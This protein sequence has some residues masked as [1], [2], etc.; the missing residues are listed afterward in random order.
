LD[1]DT[2]KALASLARTTGMTISEI[3]KRGVSALE[4]AVTE[5]D[6]RKPY[7]IYRR[8]ELG[9]DEQTRAAARDAKAAVRERIREK[10]GR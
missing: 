2:E 7:E 8:L 10:H 5:T 6:F 3:L 1:E 9:G 4:N